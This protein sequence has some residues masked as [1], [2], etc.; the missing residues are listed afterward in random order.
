[1]RRIG[2]IEEKSCEYILFFP[3]GLPGR[4][5][6]VWPQCSGKTTSFDW[7][8]MQKACSRAYYT[9]LKR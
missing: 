4:G 7:Q 5:D 3:P 8:L 9:Q 2:N 6:G 1:M